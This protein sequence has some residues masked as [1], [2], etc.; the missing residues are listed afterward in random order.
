MYTDYSYTYVV[1]HGVSVEGDLPAA[2]RDRRGG[3]SARAAAAEVNFLPYLRGR[4]ICLPKQTF[5]N[6]DMVMAL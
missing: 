3:A 4:Q 5:A 6:G 2:E 1:H